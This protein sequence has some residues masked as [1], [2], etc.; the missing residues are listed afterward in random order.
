MK[1]SAGHIYAAKTVAKASIKNEKT[2]TKLLSEI[3]IHKSLKHANIVNFV[4][5]F[6]DDIN[7]YILLAICPNQSLMELL[8]TTHVVLSTEI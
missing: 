8:K 7:V 4:D 2:K 5:C 3:K 1:D 6:E